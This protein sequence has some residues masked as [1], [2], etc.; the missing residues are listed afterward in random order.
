MLSS[1]LQQHFGYFIGGFV[2]THFTGI[3]GEGIADIVRLTGLVVFPI[4]GFLE[5]E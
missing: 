3:N 1:E 2:G 4:G 5:D